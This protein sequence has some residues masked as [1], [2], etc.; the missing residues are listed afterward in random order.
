MMAARLRAASRVGALAAEARAASR[1]GALAAEAARPPRAASRPRAA[2]RRVV[3]A[4]MRRCYNLL[5]DKLVVFSFDLGS[6]YG[7]LAA[8]RIADGVLGV[9]PR[10]EPV[11]LGAIFAYRGRGSWS[12]TDARESNLTEIDRRARSYGLPPFAWPE[13]WPGDGLAAMRA[14]T[15]A[16]ERGRA[17][18][19]ALAAYRRAFVDGDALCVEVLVEAAAS[20]GLPSAQLSTAIADPDLKAKLRATTDA[21]YAAGVT[22]VPTVRVGD[23]IF[24]GDDQLER[25]AEAAKIS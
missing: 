21:A 17:Q 4:G 14:A 16:A 23:A 10:W 22:G 13:G 7:Y 20:A 9:E 3:A 1:V 5:I 11:L 24:Y 2:R 12:Q 15:W 25:A 19:F 6:P 8:E 18:E